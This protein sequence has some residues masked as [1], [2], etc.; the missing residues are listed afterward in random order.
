MSNLLAAIQN[1]DVE[2]VRRALS[3]NMDPSV[4]VDATH[5]TALHAAVHAGH[6][7]IVTMLV[8]AGA[9]L[10][11]GNSEHL[12]PMD[13]AL[14]AKRPDIN[15]V[16]SMV[17]AGANIPRRSVNIAENR[18]YSSDQ[19]ERDEQD[20]QALEQAIE[21]L[22]DYGVERE[23]TMIAAFGANR[24]AFVQRMIDGGEDIRDRTYLVREAIVNGDEVRAVFMIRAGA[25]VNRRNGT[26]EPTVLVA[27]CLNGMVDVVDAAI[28]AGADLDVQDDQGWTAMAYAV[29][30]EQLDIVK[31]LVNAGASLGTSHV[32]G[33]FYFLHD[34]ATQG[35]EPMITY[36]LEQGLNVNEADGNG[37]TPLHCAAQYGHATAARALLDAGA[38]RHAQDIFGRTPLDVATDDARVHLESLVL[39]DALDRET[40]RPSVGRARR[41]L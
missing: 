41:R 30:A 29:D 28:A 23:T 24:L 35:M 19:D 10:N 3:E 5:N 40:D 37:I 38:D 39:Q 27:A 26:D 33:K 17:E 14:S 36:L 20:F 11:V 18:L 1:N 22:H 13:L 4:V 6:P 12:S 9:N 34:A 2:T 21:L 32:T 31:S 7:D 15:I 16:R 8:N 25:D